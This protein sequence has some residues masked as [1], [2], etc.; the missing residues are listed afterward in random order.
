MAVKMSITGTT[1][2]EHQRLEPKASILMVK[3]SLHA[4]GTV[5]CGYVVSGRSGQ[6]FI[7]LDQDKSF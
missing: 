4:A 6:W 5:I 2:L 7:S 1:P 3:E